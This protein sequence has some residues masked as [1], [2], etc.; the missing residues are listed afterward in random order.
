MCHVV[1]FFLSSS[2]LQQIISNWRLVVHRNTRKPLDLRAFPAWRLQLFLWA[3]R[4]AV[5]VKG[6]TNWRMSLR[7]RLDEETVFQAAQAV[8]QPRIRKPMIV[9]KDV[10]QLLHFKAANALRT[11]RDNDL[12]Y[13]ILQAWNGAVVSATLAQIDAPSRAA[14]H[15]PTPT[16]PRL[17]TGRLA[18]QRL[19]A[20]P[21]VF[22][23]S[24][25]TMVHILQAWQDACIVSRQGHQHIKTAAARI[26]RETLRLVWHTWYHLGRAEKAQRT[27]QRMHIQSLKVFASRTS[28][29]TL[30]LIWKTWLV[31][32]RFSKASSRRDD[33]LRRLGVEASEA[34]RSVWRCGQ[35]LVLFRGWHWLT[36]HCTLHRASEQRQQQLE[37]DLQDLRLRHRILEGAHA[38]RSS[39]AQRYGEAM[40]FG[41][42]RDSIRIWRLKCHIATSEIKKILEEIWLLWVCYIHE[43]HEHKDRDS[44]YQRQ[45][46]KLKHVSAK[47]TVCLYMLSKCSSCSAAFHAWALVLAQKRHERLRSSQKERHFEGQVVAWCRRGV[48]K[49]CRDALWSWSFYLRGRQLMNRITQLTYLRVLEEDAAILRDCCR[50]WRTLT[51]RRRHGCDHLLMRQLQRGRSTLHFAFQCWLYFWTVAIQEQLELQ[52]KVRSE[53]LMQSSAMRRSKQELRCTF[54]AWYQHL[55]A[56]HRVDVSLALAQSEVEWLSH[57]CFNAWR[58]ATILGARQNHEA[59]LQQRRQWAESAR[60]DR[61]LLRHCIG[62]W[63]GEILQLRNQQ[64]DGLKAQLLQL[65]NLLSER[66][67]RCTSDRALPAIVACWRNA[68]S[69][70]RRNRMKNTLLLST[71]MRSWTSLWSSKRHTATKKMLWAVEKLS[72]RL[73]HEKLLQLCRGVFQAWCQAKASAHLGRALTQRLQQLRGEG[74]L[75]IGFLG[76]TAAILMKRQRRLQHFKF[77]MQTK[78]SRDLNLTRALTF[79]HWRGAVSS[80]APRVYA[81]SLW[82]KCLGHRTLLD[83]VFRSWRSLRAEPRIESGAI[84]A[85]DEMLEL[86]K[87]LETQNADLLLL[88]QERANAN[89]LME[90]ELQDSNLPVES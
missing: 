50:F 44:R 56:A 46:G 71:C 24:T 30:H 72:A 38:T 8:F 55:Q 85:A 36:L 17:W 26:C 62:G 49:L 41:R 51:S 32:S 28:R 89:A 80:P 65:Q 12:A 57:A 11:L 83:L 54:L 9:P 77:Q 13:F 29:H 90:V 25:I 18:G 69:V 67:E 84:Q 35:A 42:W 53:Q 58:L 60:Q 14:V 15:Q 2:L 59:R 43:S 48:L 75:R 78:T 63:R 47:A 33:Q 39:E 37:G 87:C 45:L 20:R 7:R 23:R 64:V 21:I 19:P 66:M 74:L 4:S 79:Y 22:R 3:W 27:L 70:N 52:S 10:I 61:Y 40:M 34:L 88:L 82:V 5:E 86:C 1:V 16:R 73:L 68:A 76:W 31:A 81:Y 6:S